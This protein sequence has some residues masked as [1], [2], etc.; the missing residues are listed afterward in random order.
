MINNMLKKLG[1]NNSLKDCENVPRS[2][3]VFTLTYE[4]MVHQRSGLFPQQSVVSE[5]V[6]ESRHFRVPLVEQK[7]R[8]N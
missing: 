7:F 8:E 5:D 3:K 2:V 4:Q 1:N 6:F